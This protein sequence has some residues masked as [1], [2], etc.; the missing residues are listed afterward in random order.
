MGTKKKQKTATFTIKIKCD[1]RVAVIADPHCGHMVGLTPRSFRTDPV[2]GYALLRT[3]RRKWADIRDECWD[4]YL[5]EMKAIRPVS[6]L[7]VNGDCIDGRGEKSGS[8][9][10]LTVDR[11]E[12]CQMAVSCILVAQ[13]ER[14]VMTYGTAYHAGD[15]EDFENLIANTIQEKHGI[16]TK[17]G[18]HEWVDVNGTVFD[19][20][21]H[22]GRSTIPHGRHTAVARERLHNAL[23]AEAGEQPEAQIFIRSH[24]HYSTYCGEPGK[25]IALTTPALQA[26]GTKYGS[27][28]MSGRVDWG[29]LHFD[30]EPDGTWHM[31]PHVIPIKA[32]KAKALKV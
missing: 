9:E 20:K 3:K 27:R 24:V 8:T 14:V 10:L 31:Y 22:I 19:I 6:L 17:I 21:H 2:K 7:V 16:E 32:Q 11:E 4:R 13:P 18:S 25:W 23:W 15:R 1:K 29:F 26:M 30:I 28:V 12:Q 5:A